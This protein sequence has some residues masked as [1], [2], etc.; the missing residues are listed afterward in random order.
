MSK[1]VDQRLPQ[2]SGE[3]GG[4]KQY[5]AI[6]TPWEKLIGFQEA[7]HYVNRFEQ[8]L[9]T[10]VM[11]A[12]RILIPDYEERSEL[13]CRDAFDRLYDFGS[14]YGVNGDYKLNMHPFMSGQFVGALI[15]DEG[16]D[17][18]LMCGRCQDFGTYRA[19]K[20][21]DECPWDIVGTELCRAT[22]MSLQ[23]SANA[24]AERRRKG[25]T[26]EYAMVEARGAGDRHCRIV[27]ESREKYPMPEHK[28]WESFGPIATAD[29]IKYTPEEE[30]V[31]E[32]M[33]FREECDYKFINGT[34]SV[35]ESGAA[36]MV[37][38]STAAS[39]YLL[40]AIEE[41]IRRERFT[42]AF[43]YHV[44]HMVCEASGKAAFGERYAVKAA[45]EYLGV[46]QEIGE[47]GRILGGIIELDLQ[48]LNVPYEIEAFNKEEVVYV[49]DRAGLEITGTK[50]LPEC[51]LWYWEGAAK[52]LI[53][54]QWKLWEEDSPEGKMR[55]KIA[56]KIDKFQ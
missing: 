39:L 8:V 47:D 35:D 56:K 24:S 51:H 41:G 5:Y 37:T 9:S 11:Q 14:M 29:Q 45:R 27:A 54:A 44:V 50:M 49:I 38:L 13:M 20:E 42:R 21:L 33:V 3:N 40:P 12:Y 31:K 52:T 18:L 48:A 19:E 15:G 46:P 43:A 23:S 25:P 34:C 36:T 32:P 22:T 4:L 53:N 10:S 16:D 6:K 30:C 7:M 2:N 26:M 55:I 28:L 17:A 1:K